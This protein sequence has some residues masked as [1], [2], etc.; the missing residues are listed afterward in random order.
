MTITAK[1][2][3]TLPWR[4][5]VYRCDKHKTADLPMTVMRVHLEKLHR[6]RRD[7]A[8]LKM[9]EARMAIL[10]ARPSA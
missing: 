7:R 1:Y 9:S 3:G 4:H 6:M 10:K 5:W 8:D 2:S